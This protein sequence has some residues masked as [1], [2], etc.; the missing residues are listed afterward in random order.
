MIG[1]NIKT[2]FS[3]DCTSPY[4][5]KSNLFCTVGLRHALMHANAW[6][7]ISTELF[8]IKLCSVLTGMF[9]RD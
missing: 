8:R 6:N 4:K 1:L 2:A 5:P 9:Y 3:T 7:K